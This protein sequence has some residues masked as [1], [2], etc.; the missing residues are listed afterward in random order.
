MAGHMDNNGE[1]C[2]R[3]DVG[4]FSAMVKSL[5]IILNG[6]ESHP[7]VLIRGDNAILV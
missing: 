3:Q 5:N 2:R 1:G 4:P 7:D 6:I